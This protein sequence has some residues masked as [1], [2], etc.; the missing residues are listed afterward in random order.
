MNQ[1]NSI[2]ASAVFTSLTV[3]LALGNDGVIPPG[4]T[5]SGYNNLF[6]SIEAACGIGLT[7][8]LDGPGKSGDPATSFNN[9]SGSGILI[10]PNMVLTSAHVIRNRFPDAGLFNNSN[11]I[12]E[13]GPLDDEIIDNNGVPIFTVR[14][15]LNTDGVTVGTLGGGGDSYFQVPIKRVL[16]AQKTGE[17]TQPNGTLQNEYE[18]DVAILIL[19]DYENDMEDN[20]LWSEGWVTHIDPLPVSPLKLKS[21]VPFT[22]GT[23][24]YG[25]VPDHTT[26]F[27]CGRGT[28]RYREFE[29]SHAVIGWSNRDDQLGI[30]ARLRGYPYKGLHVTDPTFT[31]GTQSGVPGNY[32]DGDPNGAY[33]TGDSGSVLVTTA[34]NGDVLP[35]FG[36]SGGNVNITNLYKSLTWDLY[37]ETNPPPVFGSPTLLATSIYDVTAHAAPVNGSYD[38]SNWSIDAADAI[39]IASGN[40]VL[41]DAADWNQ[42]GQ[43]SPL[44][45][46]KYV[47]DLESAL[48]PYFSTPLFPLSSGLE[49]VDGN[50][51][52][53]T[54]DSVALSGML[55]FDAEEF[56]IHDY[57]ASGDID[58]GDID[59]I[60]QV[61]ATR[62]TSTIIG[63]PGPLLFDHGLMGDLDR[64]GDRDSDDVGIAFLYHGIGGFEG[65]Y[66]DDPMYDVVFDTNLD[67][68]IDLYDEQVLAKALLPGEFYANS[69][70]SPDWQRTLNDV[71]Q[72]MEN[73][74]RASLPVTPQ[75]FDLVGNDWKVG[76]GY[77]SPDF[78]QTNL[79]PSP[80]SD[81]TLLDYQFFTEAPSDISVDIQY[82]LTSW[83][84]LDM[85]DVV[86]TDS[87]LDFWF[88]DTNNDGR[89]NILD[90]QFL[91]MTMQGS[92]P[93]YWDANSDGAYTIIDTNWWLKVFLLESPYGQGFLGDFDGSASPKCNCQWTF[94]EYS[95]DVTASNYCENLTSITCPEPELV[96]VPMTDPQADCDDLIAMRQLGFGILFESGIQYGDE[97]FIVQLDADLDGDMD[98][99]DLKEIL[100]LLLQGDITFDGHLN[101]FDMLEFSDRYPSALGASTNDPNY[102][103]DIDIDRNGLI[104]ASDLNEMILLQ[105]STHCN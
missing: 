26:P 55:G 41:G 38:S 27:C 98:F 34:E 64:D 30:D 13:Y 28:L 94:G 90:I 89:V 91:N 68:V 18:F 40:G 105:N 69:N 63:Q 59:I 71:L 74:S 25:P 92:S 96:F 5:Q 45:Y 29:D 103:I 19:A 67:Q 50:G 42:D 32:S 11:P 1:L 35:V 97:D 4:P 54:M 20:G 56:L 14:F 87:L 12:L 79:A 80:S 86:Q 10:A 57:N 52:F 53:N 73:T 47:E 46:S 15:R 31:V 6:Q 21:R 22:I 7:I 77:H 24:G 60:D 33:G 61:L 88:L 48:N 16:F 37:F 95:F 44:D 17:S 104:D 93:G 58:Q 23:A 72:V 8:R 39:A 51:R 78:S 2:I 82:M 65:I 85:D 36:I 84:D 83:R 43:I 102:D 75:A 9:I 3:G 49:D 81:F 76:G 100:Y 66:V 101:A 62:G 70:L 99:Y